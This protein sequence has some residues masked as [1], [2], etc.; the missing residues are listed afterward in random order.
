MDASPEGIH[1]RRLTAKE[2]IFPT[3]PTVAEALQANGLTR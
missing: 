3:W 2:Q 1:Y